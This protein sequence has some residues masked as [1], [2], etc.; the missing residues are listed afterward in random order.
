MGIVLTTCAFILSK[1]RITD[2]GTF[3][4]GSTLIL[5]GMLL[6]IGKKSRRIKK[7]PEDSTSPKVSFL[8]QVNI[9]KKEEKSSDYLS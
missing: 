4:A 7:K 6:V 5:I 9:T 3:W 1:S 8:F 2:V